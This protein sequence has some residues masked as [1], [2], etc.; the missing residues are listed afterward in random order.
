MDY[1][2]QSENTELAYDLRQFLSR[3]IGSYLIDL[4]R[5]EDEK[6]YSEWLVCLDKLCYVVLPKIASTRD[7][8]TIEDLDEKKAYD[9]LREEL[10][11][12]A[13][14]YPK[15][16]LGQQKNEEGVAKLSHKL[17]QMKSYIIQIMHR[18]GYFGT[19]WDDAGL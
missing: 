4:K 13:K 7:D 9:K 1:N 8:K 2:Q 6:D 3:F 5:A 11:T 12:L 10:I 15:V 19:K 14:E 16:F 18:E 17:F